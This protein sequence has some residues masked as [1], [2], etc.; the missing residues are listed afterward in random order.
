VTDL[1]VEEALEQI[2]RHDI[3]SVRVVFAD[4]HG[5][6]RGK[7][8]A[9]TS[10]ERAFEHGIGVPGSLLHKDTGNT[11]A[12]D[13]WKPSGDATLD[14]L[15][16]A[17]N[18]VMRPDPSTLRQL[19][20]ADGTAIVLSD[21]ESDSGQAIPHSTRGICAR[22]VERL[23]AHQLTFIAGLELEFHLY[24]VDA[25]GQLTHSH[26]GWDL[27]GEGTLDRIEPAIEPIRRGL[28]SMGLPP[29]TIE[30]ELG[31]SQIEMTFAPTVGLDVADQA[32]LVR[33][34]IRHIA[35]RTGFRASFMSRPRVD[36][37]SFP[38]GWHLHQSLASCADSTRSSAF[39][40]TDAT[41]LLSDLGRNYV[42]GLLH[43]ASAA[44]LLTTPTV[45]GYKRYRPRAITPDRV[46]WSRDHRGAM[47]RVIG[48]PGDPATRVEN[49]VGDPAANPYLLVASQIFSGLDGIEHNRTPPPPTESPYEPEGGPPLPRT[50][51]DAIAAFDASPLFRDVLGD[52]V[53][54]YLVTL[55]GSEWNRFNA[56]VTDWE[57]REYFDL[58]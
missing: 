7:T 31:P 22:A 37:E 26:P 18:V 24:A 28:V 17:R 50:L 14:A 6:L 36:G 35:R 46:S 47:L 9:A 33:T 48:G 34:A 49:R 8:V 58:F 51:G 12:I 10:M 56:A 13:L 40:P 45:T 30:A 27:L 38:S 44:C 15:V 57:Q 29:V 43:H 25:G 4:Q 54:D 42:A 1:R 5:L 32:M 21:L 3:H 16:G 11:Y 53:V 2:R 20:W 41:R 39:T 52:G 55:K 19:P 23:D